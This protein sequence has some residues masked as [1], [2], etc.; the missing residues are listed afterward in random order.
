MPVIRIKPVF[1]AKTKCTLLDKG[2]ITLTLNDN[3]LITRTNYQYHGPVDDDDE[4]IGTRDH[5]VNEK[6]FIKK[7]DISMIGIGYDNDQET[8]FL[9]II[10]Q[11]NKT[12]INL[13]SPEQANEVIDTL[14]K[15]QLNQL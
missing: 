8:Y 13:E 9:S 14:I 11:N 4:T 15:W 3:H 2:G 7:D 12:W 1:G 5:M 10:S 6:S